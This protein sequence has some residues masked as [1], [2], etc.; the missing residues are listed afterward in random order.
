VKGPVSEASVEARVVKWARERGWITRKLN[1]LGYRAWPDRLFI[2]DVF[3][4]AFIEFKRP[5]N[6]PTVQQKAFLDH[7]TSRGFNVAWYDDADAAIAFLD[8]LDSLAPRRKMG[9]RRL[10]E[11]RGALPA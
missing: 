2:R 9:T 4:F 8:H 11:A 7:L 3:C 1:G 5:G 10:S 6:V